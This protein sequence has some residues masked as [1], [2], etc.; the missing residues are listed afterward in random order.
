MNNEMS[1]EDLAGILRAQAWERAKGELNAVRVTYWGSRD[2]G[3]LDEF[4]LRLE[5]F[6]REIEDLGLND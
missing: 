6:I 4:D 2:E 1:N 3:K 5:I